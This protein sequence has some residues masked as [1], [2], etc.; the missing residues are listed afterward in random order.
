[1]VKR[2][3]TMP[4]SASPVEK[5]KEA[6]RQQQK[7]QDSKFQ[8]YNRRLTMSEEMD[9][10]IHPRF[11][12]PFINAIIN[13]LN[14]S[15][16]RGR[17][18]DS[19]QGGM[20]ISLD[21]SVALPVLGTVVTLAVTN[22]LQ[23][24]K[25]TIGEAEVLRS[26][27]GAGLLDNGNGIAL[28]Y[29]STLCDD[30]TESYVLSGVNQKTRLSG[31]AD[32]AAIDINYLGNYRRDLITCQLK[33]FTLALTVGVSLAS[34]Y[35]GLAYHSVATNQQA[36]PDL[37][38][39][40]TMVA[41]MPGFLATACALMVAQKSISI[42][43]IDAYLLILKKYS[44]L[45]QYPREYRGWESAYRKY[46]H[47][48]KSNACKS[49]DASK[50]CGELRNEERQKTL[51]RKLLSGPRIGIYHV[52]VYLS[53]FI[54]FALSTILVA[55]ELLKYQWG[56]LCYMIVASLINTITVFASIALLYVF[57]HL[58]K[59][60]YS[61]DYF[62]RCWIDVLNKCRVQV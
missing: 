62:K 23:T 17:V 28:E 57:Y 61:I 29:V 9:R 40:R 24:F 21:E 18:L 36:N 55:T 10:R 7:G 13:T 58:R 12:P 50:K 43:R 4:H 8:I 3:L 20:A 11:E 6:Q 46:R 34:A 41:A 33:L 22:A 44:I 49:C 30:E 45:K 25:K 60:K 56:N 14:G 47:L 42:Q 37:S 27:T 16:I 53:F 31:Q 38:F 19:S 54:A 59:G 5:I 32:L 48:L 2:C 51:T 39:W 26:W 52:I 35:F 15:E 1:M